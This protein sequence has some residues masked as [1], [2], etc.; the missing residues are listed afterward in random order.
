MCQVSSHVSLVCGSWNVPLLSHVDMCGVGMS[1]CTHAIRRIS[2][3]A[4]AQDIALCGSD[5]YLLRQA[6]FGPKGTV[7][8]LHEDPYENAFCQA[9]A[10]SPVC[11]VIRMYADSRHGG[12]GDRKRKVAQHP[13]VVPL[14][15]TAIQQCPSAAGLLDVLGLL[16]CVAGARL[17]SVF[18]PPLFDLAV[19]TRL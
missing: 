1:P 2:C 16:V 18:R 14:C 7:T 10:S 5:G 11:C 19:S 12:R 9:P 3:D 4:L 15:M 17:H 6:F 8:P 13:S